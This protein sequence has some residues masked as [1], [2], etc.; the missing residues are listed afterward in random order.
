MSEELEAAYH[1]LYD[2]WWNKCATLEGDD[3]RYSL[4]TNEDVILLDDA[5]EAIETLLAAQA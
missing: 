1:K 2:V 5:A 3:P 4:L